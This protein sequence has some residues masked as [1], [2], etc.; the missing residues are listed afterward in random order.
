MH[1]WIKDG[2]T[3]ICAYCTQELEEVEALD[4]LNHC[5]CAPAEQAGETQSE[6][7]ALRTALHRCHFTLSSICHL[8]GKQV[9]GNEL[10][11]IHDY[12]E[13]IRPLIGGQD[14]D[15]LQTTREGSHSHDT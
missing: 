2:P 13:S 10:R 4:E 15:Q 11:N 6:V 12:L 5:S 1:K 8:R 7:D 3:T 14:L 9:F